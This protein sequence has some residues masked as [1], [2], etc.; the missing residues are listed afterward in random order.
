MRGRQVELGCTSRFYSTAAELGICG[1]YIEKVMKSNML[2]IL[3]N[4]KDTV[5][6]QDKE[7]NN[8]IQMK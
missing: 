2:K 5:L 8:I 7:S 3:K 1:R 6:Q 4:N